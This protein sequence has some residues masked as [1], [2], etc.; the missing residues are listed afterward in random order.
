MKNAQEWLNET[1]PTKNQR[2]RVRK[3]FIDRKER[4]SFPQFQLFSDNS[5]ENITSI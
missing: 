4:G 2:E 1:Y 5:E 3:I